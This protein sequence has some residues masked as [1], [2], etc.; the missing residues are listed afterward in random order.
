MGKKIFTATAV[1]ALLLAAVVYGKE[2]FR[3]DISVYVDGVET[4][5]EVYT[6]EL[7]RPY[8]PLRDIFEAMG[9]E[10]SYNAAEKT[11]EVDC[12]DSVVNLSQYDTEN[13]ATVNGSIYLPL[14]TVSEYL[15]FTVEVLE[16]EKVISIESTEKTPVSPQN[17]DSEG[18]SGFAAKLDSLMDK[19]E[20]YVLSPISIKYALAMAANGADEETKAEILNV[21]GVSDLESCN[22]EVKEY[23]ESNAAYNQTDI[24]DLEALLEP[25]D[26]RLFVANS[27]WLNSDYISG[28][29]FSEDFKALAEENYGAEAGTVNS[30]NAVETI[31]G[32]CSEN[33]NGKIDE[34]I[35]SSD[36]LACLVNAVY[37]N[38]RWSREFDEEATEKDIF[39][40]ADGSEAEIDFM[41]QTGY[42]RYYAD[43]NIQ[44]VSMPYTNGSMAMYIALADEG[45]NALEYADK[46]E[47]KK[48]KIK[49]PKFSVETSLDASELLKNLGIEKAFDGSADA[50]HFMPMF[51]DAV[52]NGN[53]AYISNILHKTYIKTNEEGMEAAAVTSLIMAATSSLEQQELIYEFNADK[54]FTYFIRDNSNGEILFIGRFAE[55]E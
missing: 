20:N 55:G 44:M 33:T 1:F 46:T 11:A 8:V 26:T 4:D 37:F 50:Y 45:I 29:D 21:L 52:N 41:N 34:I 38:G 14:M 24:S 53:S 42:F 10:V 22:K 23:I 43:E 39:T 54:P 3:S 48:V 49:I 12:G 5:A 2:F 30:Q 40:N 27:V 47:V 19:N 35:N 7:D 18:S 32:W 31:N 36:F 25:K 6:D 51:N 16:D 28:G 13:T 17:N 15:G 9:C